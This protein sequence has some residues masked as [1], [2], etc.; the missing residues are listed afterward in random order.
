[1]SRNS[2]Y[3]VQFLCPSS[4]VF[5]RTFVT[6]ICHAGFMTAVKHDQNVTG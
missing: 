3:F 4:G 5:H 2:T 6:G 1:L